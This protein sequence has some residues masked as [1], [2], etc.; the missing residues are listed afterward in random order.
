MIFWLHHSIPVLCHPVVIVLRTIQ[1][2][3]GESQLVLCAPDWISVCL[4][5]KVDVRYVEIV[6]HSISFVVFT[7]NATGDYRPTCHKPSLSRIHPVKLGKPMQRR[8]RSNMYSTP[9]TPSMISPLFIW[10][11]W[12]L[13]RQY[14]GFQTSNHNCSHFNHLERYGLYG[15]GGGGALTFI[16][17]PN[18]FSIFR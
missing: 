18:I 17:L 9:I 6:R 1:L 16:T 5:P 15:A 11:R 13:N 4:I 7:I 10:R 8:S 2:V 3:V 14:S 12:W